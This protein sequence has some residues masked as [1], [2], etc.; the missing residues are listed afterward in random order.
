MYLRE[1]H[2]VSVLHNYTC[3]S[4]TCASVFFPGY[5][6]WSLDCNL[7]LELFTQ[8]IL[9]NTMS[10]AYIIYVYLSERWLIY[11]SDG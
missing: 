3:N 5:L 1:P 7:H 11:L 9:V 4:C 6:E 8:Y 10:I 2:K